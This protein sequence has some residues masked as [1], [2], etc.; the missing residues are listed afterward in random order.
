VGAI[1]PQIGPPA[2]PPWKT[3]DPAVYLVLTAVALIANFVHAAS[4]GLYEDDWYFAACAWLTPAREW[5]ADMWGSMRGFYLGRPM[6]ECFL[7]TSGYVGSALHSIGA[8]YVLAALLHAASVLMLYRV[9]RLR[10]PA[11]LASLGALVFAVSP[12]STIRPF[13]GGTLCLAP[14]L[15][16]LLGAFLVYARP[17]YAYA[18]YLLAI[19]SL[20]TYELLFFV[21]FAAPFFRRG[22][23]TW[24]RWALHVAICGLILAA[25]LL[26]RRHLSE[27]RL[28]EAPVG[29]PLQLVKSVIWFAVFNT[30]SSFKAY[31][32]AVYLAARETRLSSLVWSLLLAAAA[33]ACVVGMPSAQLRRTARLISPRTWWWIARVLAPGLGM[34]ALAYSLSYFT[35]TYHLAFSLVGRDTRFS[36]GAMIGSSM[37]AGGVLWYPLAICRRQ[38][39]RL[40]AGAGAV[41]FFVFLL[42]YSFVI[43]DDY[44]SEWIHINRLLTRMMALTPDAG[45]DTLL[46]VHRPWYGDQ[47]FPSGPRLP[48][49]NFQVHFVVLGFSRLF[50]NYRGPTVFVVYNDEWKRH[51][52]LHAD[53]KMYWTDPDFG[54]SQPDM[55]VPVTRIIFLVEELDGSVRRV[56]TPFTVE[57]RQ[58]IQTRPAP[59]P[60][61]RWLTLKWSPLWPVVF[62]RSPF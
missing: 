8:L 10:Y 21:F 37:V 62:P 4:F 42:L 34:I 12:L 6:Q 40:L 33:A 27:S 11:F 59:D 55:K 43:Q 58:L 52:G 53:G 54:G 22:R 29:N 39:T 20:L 15:M 30:F 49:I 61:S 56:D 24:L 28:M 7:W 23:K 17:R 47:L 1:E 46:V 5:F 50:Q 16:F 57:G 2:K 36:L 38:W 51:L 31:A 41:S 9:L 25:Y 19:L 14:G 60:P 32:Y 45:P 18:S 13:L 3:G 44:R 26:V 48:S 35:S